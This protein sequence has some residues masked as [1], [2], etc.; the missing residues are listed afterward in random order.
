MADR[1]DLGLT[2][3]ALVVSD[4]DASVEF[5]T[6][7]AGMRVVHQRND[8]GVKVAW[9]SDLTRPFVVVIIESGKVEWPLRPMGHLGVA[10]QSRAEVDRLC[11]QARRESRSV[12]GPQDSGYPV[13]YW[14]FIEDPDGHTLE[15]SYGQD[16]AFTVKD[17]QRGDQ[18]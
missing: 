18:Q 1:I 15:L 10:L 6:T 9:L 2:H 16:I 13:G 17:S 14:G 8:A 4:V 5:Y 7:Y 11:E 12:H 3:V